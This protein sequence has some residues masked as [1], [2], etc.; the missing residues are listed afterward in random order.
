M[1]RT[2]SA[3][4]SKK[5]STPPLN[6][7]SGTKLDVAV[8]REPFPADTSEHYHLSYHD[9][10]DIEVWAARQSIIS[11][12]LERGSMVYT[13]RPANR[14]TVI[15]AITTRYLLVLEKTNL[16]GMRPATDDACHV[17]SKGVFFETMHTHS[18]ACC[19]GIG[20]KII[21]RRLLCPT[22][23]NSINSPHIPHNE[24][25]MCLLLCSARC[26]LAAS[27]AAKIG[28]EASASR[29]QCL[30]SQLC[31]G[32]EWWYDV[33]V[34]E[35]AL[36]TVAGD[37]V[38]DASALEDVGGVVSAGLLSVLVGAGEDS[39]DVSGAVELAATLD[40]SMD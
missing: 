5:H 18:I 31:E 19:K 9:R 32:L 27:F 11:L 6:L 33:R 22:I 29:V 12:M 4:D 20:S 8:E 16:P 1:S 25:P 23:L 36:L 38:A 13:V 34:A 24:S 14:A 10:Y 28:G 15:C 35:V 17:Q 7:C 26:L 39:A 40:E 30:P 21:A 3:S 37:V 2:T